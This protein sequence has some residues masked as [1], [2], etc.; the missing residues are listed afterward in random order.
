M[1]PMISYCGLVCSECP[2]F[3][4]RQQDDD[5]LREKT[6]REWS[7]QFKMEIPPEAIN[8]VGCTAAG[9]HSTYCEMCEIRKCGTDK[10]LATCAGCA[11]YGCDKLAKAHQMEPECRKRLDALR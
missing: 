2:A 10:G 5:A 1:E 6:A 7:E 11:D 4:A 8:C 3:I 9:V